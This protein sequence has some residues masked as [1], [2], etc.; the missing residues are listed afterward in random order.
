M[1]T[2]IT[3]ETLYLQLL[4]KTKQLFPNFTEKQKSIITEKGF[5][6]NYQ[7]VKQFDERN[8]YFIG[9][10]DDEHLLI[11][12]E[13]APHTLIYG[14]AGSGKT[15]LLRSIQKQVVS[16]NNTSFYGISLLNNTTNPFNELLRDGIDQAFTGISELNEMCQNL[17]EE[18]RRRFFLFEKMNVNN[19]KDIN[20]ENVIVV[21][22]GFD[23]IDNALLSLNRN[24]EEYL[25]IFS[26][27]SIISSLLRTG[28]IAGFYIFISIQKFFNNSITGEMK[29]NMGRKIKLEHVNILDEQ[30]SYRLSRKGTLQ[31]YHD[32]HKVFNP[33][34]M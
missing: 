14:D 31:T 15:E 12:F 6:L 34:I 11:E 33:Y 3:E 25:Q 1:N 2:Y 20:I 13:H 27:L 18:I 21:I 23:V 8:K 30:Y 4:N 7:T 26:S 16:K 5:N 19:S 29:N 32:S 17:L 10:N 22:D 9:E 28:R 24:S